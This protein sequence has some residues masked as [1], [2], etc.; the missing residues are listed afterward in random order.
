[1]ASQPEIVNIVGNGRVDAEIDLQILCEDLQTHYEDFSLESVYVKGPGLYLNF[2]Q[3][4][5]TGV[6]ARS[7]KYIVTGASTIEELHQTREQIL[8]LFTELGILDS[9]TDTKF[10]VCNMVLTANLNKSINLDSLA[11]LVGF[12][13]MEYEPEQFPGMIY[14]PEG[15]KCVI[16]IFASGKTVITGAE[17]EDDAREAYELVREVVGQLGF[18]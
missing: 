2:G 14:R 10:G 16:L 11:I 18:T 17:S 6:I 5:P 3:D 8:E 9:P 12:E 1:M 13:N 7:G 15:V 4:S